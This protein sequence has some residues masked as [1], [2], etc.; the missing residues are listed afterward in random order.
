[1]KLNEATAR[2]AIERVMI[3]FM[4]PLFIIVIIV[5]NVSLPKN[6]HLDINRLKYRKTSH[7]SSTGYIQHN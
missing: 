1:M 5:V 6:L 2:M 3:E 7:N 4:S